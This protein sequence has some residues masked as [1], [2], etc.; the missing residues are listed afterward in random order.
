MEE[1]EMNGW[2][3]SPKEIELK[4]TPVDQY[5]DIDVNNLPKFTSIGINLIIPFE[6]CLYNETCPFYN[7][8]DRAK[9]KESALYKHLLDQLY[10]LNISITTPPNKELYNYSNITFYITYTEEQ[11][12]EI[13]ENAL[14]ITLE[15]YKIVDVEL[16]KVSSDTTK[17]T[18]NLVEANQRDNKN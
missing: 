4:I 3:V 1:K 6:L 13:L 17:I 9:N 18:L 11:E 16:V 7:I 14:N 10:P 5:S 8:S 15:E 2:F 12:R